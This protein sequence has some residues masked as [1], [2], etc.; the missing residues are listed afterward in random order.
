MVSF[1]QPIPSEGYVPLRA[2]GYW[3]RVLACFNP[4]EVVFRAQSSQAITDQPFIQFTYDNVDVGAYTDVWEGMVVYLSATPSIHDAFYRGRVRL[5]PTDTVFR[6]SWNASILADNTY[7]IVARDTDFFTRHRN[8]TL[9]DDSVAWHALPPMLAGLPT[10]IVLYDADADGEVTYT[11]DVT[12]IPVDAAATTVDLFAWSISGAGASSIDDDTLQAPTLTFQAGYHYLLRVVYTDDNG[13]SNYQISHVYAVNRTFT[14]PVGTSVVVGTI[15]HDIDDGSTV[16]LTAYADVSS[17]VDRTHVAVFAVEHFGDHSSAPRVNNVWFNGRIRS[18]SIRTEGSAEAGQI[19]QVTFTAEGITAYMRRL[20]IP[21]DIVRTTATPNEWG[22]GIWNPYRMAVYA[23]WAYTTLTNICSFSVEDGAFAAWQIGGEPRGIDGGKALDV[24]TGLLSP[25]KAA[26]NFAPSGEIHLARTISYRPDRTGIETVAIFELQDMLD[27]DIDE[28]SSRTTS[29]VVA[30]GGVFDSDTDTWTIYQAHAPTVVFGEGEIRELTREI[31]A[32]DSTITEAQD[33]L[34]GRA[35][36]EYAFNNAKPLMRLALFDSWAGVLIPTNFQRWASV[37]PASANLRGRAY[38]STDYWQ[39]QSVTLGID[40]NGTVATSGEWYRETSFSDAQV[41]SEL[42]PE[43]LSDMNPVLPDWPNE[44][45]FPTDP[46]EN[47][48]TDFPSLD[49]YLP[50]DPFSGMV[51]YAPLPPDVAANAARR[52]GKVNCQVV[53]PLFSASTNVTSSRLTVN[54]AP[55]LLTAS[56]S[57]QISGDAWTQVFNFL[58]TDGGFTPL[59]PTTTYT[60][61]V[62]WVAGLDP[63]SCTLEADIQLIFPAPGDVTGIS[64]GFNA[65]PP[66]VTDEASRI[67]WIRGYNGMSLDIDSQVAIT[68]GTNQSHAWAGTA[69][70]V[71]SLKLTLTPANLNTSCESTDGSGVIV[72]CVISGVG[73][74][75]FTGATGAPQEADTFYKYQRHT[76]GEN[77]GEIDLSTVVALGPLEGLFIDNAVY[78]P[79]NGVPPFN[80]SNRYPNLPFTGT[81]NLI[82]AR[83]Q[84]NSY[85]NVQRVYQTTEVCRKL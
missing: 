17:F 36:N 61:G 57:A 66:S 13:E 39:M 75:P 8:D 40:V 24:L 31:L 14:A 5:A 78:V 49:E 15:G 7:V 35:A 52:Q 56:G 65:S 81:G 33:E 34:A 64:F 50:G 54:G 4:P 68:Y 82:L 16:S 2:S 67:K 63:G 43:N 48:P 25:I 10:A 42:L 77:E 20:E 62:G 37:I 29:Q 70:P 73:S 46:L 58:L 47:Y 28:D 9:I 74:N 59:A 85:T 53:Q 84:F 51:A 32:A 41:D 30:F 26:P 44:P 18:S 72:S 11:P 69:T 22:E 55:Y 6:I 19:Q 83:M 3:T 45:A 12:G 60:E 80:E 21:S 71:D 38:S 23:L 1:P 27:F 79:S 76:D